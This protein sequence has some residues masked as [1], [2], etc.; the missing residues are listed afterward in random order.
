[1]R[2]I[3]PQQAKYQSECTARVKKLN[4]SRESAPRACVITYGCQ[5]NESDS[6]K[7][8]GML[9]EM[10]YLISDDPKTSDVVIFNT[11]AVR[12]NAELK[13]FGNVGA[14]KHAKRKNPDMIIGVC[15]CMMQQPHISE[16]IKSKYNHI[17]IVFGPHA[18]YRLPEILER[19][20]EK[21]RVFEV[22]NS[23]GEI[24]EGIPVLREPPPLAKV[25]IMYGCNNFCTYCIVPYVRGRERS[26]KA[27]DILAEVRS[28]AEQGYKEV[29]LLGQNV[30]S[31]GNPINS[32]ENIS[33][34]ELLR[35]VCKTDG[36]ERVRFMTSH[37][38]DLSDELI[39][40]IAEEDKICKQL[41]LPIQSGSDKVLRDMNRGYTAER[42][43]ERLDKVRELIPD[44][45]VTSDIIVGFPTETNEDFEDTLD[46]IRRAR[47]DMVFSFIYSKRV[48]TPAAK[49]NPFLTD[50]EIHR[51]FDRL[52]EVQNEIS[53]QKN[54]EY[55]GR[56]EE[57]L[58]EGESKTNPEYM[59][60]RTNGGKT[61]NFKGGSEFVSRLVPVKIIKAQT[62][63][64]T[65][66]LCE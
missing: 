30:N 53:K 44:I 7:L 14:L 31:F 29:M 42:Y 66:E 49:M 23:D 62:W 38:K 36:I 32:D 43:M 21:N 1:M 19:A 8:R 9:C 15:G 48:G 40:A 2:E 64:L 63:S 39:Y 26:R 55:V 20:L 56:V 47:Y 6:E 59:C 37:P 35:M 45:T 22:E 11:C 57:I 13:V 10:G 3:T 58:V 33:F 34:P 27:A 60:G 61:V 12:E 51:N 46:I 65:G 25:P 4:L 50:E 41:H 18:L 24:V 5:Q 54:D 17:D 16:T 28:S 52:L